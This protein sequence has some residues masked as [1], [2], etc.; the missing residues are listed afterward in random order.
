MK[1]K[2][3]IT[4][5]VSFFSLFLVLENYTAYGTMNIESNQAPAPFSRENSSKLPSSVSSSWYTIAQN[6]IQKSEY[7]VTWQDNTNLPEIKAAYQ[8]PNRSHNLRIYFTPKGIRVIPRTKTSDW[9]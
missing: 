7:N 6:N 2:V 9:T 5:L 8:T 4:L 1:I 3:L